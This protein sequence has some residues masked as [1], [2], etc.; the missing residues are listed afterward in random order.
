MAKGFTT[1][2]VWVA[3][4][5]VSRRIYVFRRKKDAEAFQE[6]EQ[7]RGRYCTVERMSLTDGVP[8]A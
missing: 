1:D 3:V 5:G 4:W 7:G 8:E 2:V 6:R